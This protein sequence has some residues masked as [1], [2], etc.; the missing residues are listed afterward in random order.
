MARLRDDLRSLV[1]YPERHNAPIKG[2]NTLL[3]KLAKSLQFKSIPE[4]ENSTPY[5]AVKPEPEPG[6]KGEVDLRPSAKQKKQKKY[7][8]HTGLV[9]T[10]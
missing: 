4:S 2:A 9:E 6:F 8:P 1:K 7:N 10:V 5:E 3:V